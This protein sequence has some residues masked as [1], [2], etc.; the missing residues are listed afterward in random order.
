MRVNLKTDI[1]NNYA[2]EAPFVSASSKT[3]QAEKLING[4][5][6]LMEYLAPNPDRLYMVRVNGESM[7]D[8]GIYDGDILIVD[9]KQSPRDG[10]VVIAALNGEMLVKTYR[11]IDNEAYLFSANKN[12]LPIKVMPIW[13]L[14]IQGVVKHVIRNI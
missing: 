12:F 10:L 8:E 3:K 9:K 4:N 14:N 7:I 13:E 11:I 2:F 6:D 1:K 5:L